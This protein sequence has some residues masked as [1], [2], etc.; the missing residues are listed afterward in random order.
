MID[1]SVQ[2]LRIGGPHWY[3][4]IR[5]IWRTDY[6]NKMTFKIYRGLTE[7]S[8]SLVH[9]YV[10]TKGTKDYTWDDTHEVDVPESDN[11]KLGNRFRNYFYKIESYL[12]SGILRETTDTV[13]W[14]AGMY[15][16]YEM[17]I[18][19]GHEFYFKKIAGTPCFLFKRKVLERSGQHCPVC[20]DKS[21]GGPRKTH[22][23]GVGST[24][25]ECLNT[26]I[27][28]PY[29]DPVEAWVRIKNPEKDNQD[30]DKL[31]KRYKF[32]TIICD[33]NGLPVIR[34]G[35]VLLDVIDRVFYGVNKVS[36]VGKRHSGVKQDIMA[37]EM[38][39]EKP[40]YRWLEIAAADNKDVINELIRQSKERKF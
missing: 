16:R 20:W 21:T 19:R 39:N 8:V 11:I 18:M 29:H 12:P 25:K 22:L 24:C 27:I 14:D 6:E 28:D 26:G 2:I 38:A 15:T 32:E 9:T 33:A 10:G 23:G 17:E 5:L 1:I 7:D 37:V 30:A 4:K 40:E 31:A 13:S 3:P 36:H 34:P 35:D